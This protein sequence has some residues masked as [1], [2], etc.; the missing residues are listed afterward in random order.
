MTDY[1]KLIEQLRSGEV[2]YYDGRS[3]DAIEALQAENERLKVERENDAFR[4]VWAMNWMRMSVHDHGFTKHV[5]ERGGMGD[6][7][8]C[9]TYVDKCA[10]ATQEAAHGIG[11]TP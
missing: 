11:G 8:D 10:G 1:T 7:S 6:Y 2:S 3:A 5:L 9:A 4:L